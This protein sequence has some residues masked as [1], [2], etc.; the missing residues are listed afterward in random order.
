MKKKILIVDDEI[1]VRES[2]QQLLGRDFFI[3]TADSVKKAREI[4]HNDVFDLVLLDVILQD[5]SGIAILKEFKN[6]NP[7]IPVIMITGTRHVRT[8]VNAMKLGAFDYLNKPFTKEELLSTVTNAIQLKE[9]EDNLMTFFD[10][11]Q[12]EIFFGN[13]IGKSPP[14]L[15]IFKRVAQVMNSS[16]T[17]LIEGESGTGKELVAK[18]IHYHGIRR[19]YPFIPVHIASLPDTL[20]ES[21]LFGHE[22]GSFTGASNMKRGIFEEANKGTLFLDEISDIPMP[23][24]VKLLR[25]LQE[26]EVRRVGSTKSIKIDI[27]LIAATNSNLWQL[28]EKGLF[29]EDLFYRISVV[30]ICMPGLRERVEDIP[31]LVHHFLGIYGKKSNTK[32]K[33]FTKEALELLKDYSWPGN[34]RELEHLIE[35]LLITV[36]NKWVLPEDMPLHICNNNTKF[37]NDTLNETVSEY[38]RRIIEDALVK[39]NG[40]IVKAADSLGTTRRVLR[41]KIDKLGIA[42]TK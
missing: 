11:K 5:S 30:P 24:Q 23:V 37:Q 2:L 12:K 4:W 41:Y 34:V 15:E 22:K 27:R 36:D 19:K 31:T 33:G 40:T 8:A 13:I 39:A 10:K 21:E 9:Q 28:V 18:A 25:V 32:V 35:Q 29:R 38:E 42:V 1:G 3:S 17:V 26:R 7:K 16:S 14:M 6:E 20:L